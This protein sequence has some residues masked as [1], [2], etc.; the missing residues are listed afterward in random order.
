[1][2][3]GLMLGIVAT[4]AILSLAGCDLGNAHPSVTAGTLPSQSTQPTLITPPVKPSSSW[5][6][7]PATAQVSSTITAPAPLVLTWDPTS[8]VGSAPSRYI[9][10]DYRGRVV[11][12][13]TIDQ[14]SQAAGVSIAPDGSR[15]L[16]GGRLLYDVYGHRLA[17]IYADDL[18]QPIWADDSSHLCG[19]PG[20]ANNASSTGVLVEVSAVGQVRT[21]ASLGQGGWGVIACSPDADRVVVSDS[22]GGST[23]RALKWVVLRLSTGGP[24]ATYPGWSAIGAV[25]THDGRLLA[26]DEASGISIRDMATGQEL[27]RIVRWGSQ[28]GYPLIG[29]AVVFSWDGTRLLIDGG[30]AGGGFHPEWMVHWATNRNVTTNTGTN[31]A[32]RGMGDAVPMIPGSAFFLPPGDVTADAAAAHLLTASGSLQR[33]SD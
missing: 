18:P 13:L 20:T 3:R 31:P 25:A 4:L 21:V 8:E 14:Y 19:F 17:D 15:L 24:I 11:G 16:I 9:A 7:S 12:T 2:P 30:G 6:P 26:V 32:L 28:A 10:R 5:T 27:A 22:T 23:V 33:L 1:M 29:A